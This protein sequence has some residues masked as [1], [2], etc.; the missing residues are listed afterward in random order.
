MEGEY[1]LF[2]S[3]DWVAEKQNLADGADQRKKILA[4]F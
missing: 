1:R 3:P 4:V 2:L